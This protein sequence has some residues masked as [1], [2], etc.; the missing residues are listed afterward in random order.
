MKFTCCRVSI[1]TNSKI[2]RSFFKVSKSV[3]WS[4]TNPCLF[5]SGNSFHQK[6]LYHNLLVLCVAMHVT[7]KLLVLRLLCDLIFQKYHSSLSLSELNFF[8]FLFCIDDIFARGK[9]SIKISLLLINSNENAL[10]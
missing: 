8:N 4:P 10:Q 2:T 7:L 5:Q 3:K 1:V 6:I 9:F